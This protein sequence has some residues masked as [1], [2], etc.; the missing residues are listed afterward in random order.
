M[1][2]PEL[3]VITEEQAQIAKPGKF[4]LN[5]FRSKRGSAAAVEVL[6]TALPVLKLSEAKDFVRLHPDEEDYWTTELC[7]VNV[8]AKGQ[9]KDTLHLIDDDL[10]AIAIPRKPLLRYRL[11]L[12]TKPYDVHFLAVVPSQNL[13]YDWN[14]SNLKAC[15][16]AK[17]QWVEVYSLKGENKEGYGFTPAE[18]QE[19]FAEPIWGS[20][21]LW[22]RIGLTFEGRTIE[23][24]NSD[25]LK[26][27]RGA[28]VS[29]S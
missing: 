24:A 3:K 20:Q 28:K 22:E 8:P 16:R 12:A 6:P 27:L 25:A 10:A 2:T 26:R 18:N 15:L 19:A 9:K 7:F 5:K 4:D 21:T 29:A 23:D 13:D 14:S 1:T 17:D 11:A